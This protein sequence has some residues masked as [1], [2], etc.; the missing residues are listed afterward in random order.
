MN[1]AVVY[2]IGLAGNLLFGF[3]SLWQIIDCYKRK[4]TSGLSRGMLLA[5][6][7]GNI[8]CALFIHLTTGFRLWPQFVNYGFATLWLIILFIMMFIYKGNDNG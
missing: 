2:L 5:D 1:D 7:G 8:A 4:S 3:K 6:F